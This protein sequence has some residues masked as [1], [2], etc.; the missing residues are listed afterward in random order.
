MNE[1]IRIQ[2]TNQIDLI[3]QELEKAARFSKHTRRTYRGILVRFEE[4]REG[5]P[6][7]K[8]LVEEYQGI[9]KEERGLSYVTVNHHTAAIRWW[10]RRLIDLV[11][12]VPLP[13]KPAARENWKEVREEIERHCKRVAKVENISGERVP[14]GRSIN[15]SELRELMIACV[16]DQTPAGGRDRA[17]F[18]LAWDTGMRR[19]ELAKLVI[20]DIVAEDNG[21]GPAYTLIVSGKGNKQR[22][23]FVYGGTAK[24][25]KFWLNIR[26]AEP[27]PVF[28]RIRKGGHTVPKHKLSGEALRLLLEKRIKQAR[29]SP[30]TWHDFRRTLIGNKLDRGYDLVT[31]GKFVGHASTNTTA[32]YDRRPEEAQKNMARDSAVPYHEMGLMDVPG[33]DG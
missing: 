26:G 2:K 31:I 17:M 10:A 11:Y 7:T 30:F 4:W 20:E 27:G 28:C 6:L 8:R 33:D 3:F 24:C 19:A 15:E 22:K 1:L 14:A 16:Q 21:N 29:L 5:R 18:A 32:M 12:D 9:L 25:L 23:S 13:D